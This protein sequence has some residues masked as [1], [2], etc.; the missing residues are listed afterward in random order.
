MP[1]SCRKS[2]WPRKKRAQSL[3]QLHMS[4]AREWNLRQPSAMRIWPW[5]PRL[6]LLHLAMVF[7]ALGAVCPAAVGADYSLLGF[8]TVGYALS[9]MRA[10][11]L[12]Y[13][14]KR[15][16][17]RADSLIGIQGEVQIDPQWGATLQL[18]GGAPRDKDNGFEA[19]IRWAFV[20]YRPSNEWLIRAGRL[21]PPILNHTPNSEVG[22]TY[23]FARLPA[24][25]YSLSPV[26]DLQGVAIARG[27]EHG[28]AESRVETYLGKAEVKFRIPFQRDPSQQV[29]PDK[30][31]P[32]SVDLVGM[33]V[34]RTSSRLSLA[35]GVHHA[36]IRPAQGR[37]FVESLIPL[38]VP[39]PAPLGGPVFVPGRE[40]DEIN[41]LALTVSG[42]YRI[43][44]L[45]ITTEVVRRTISET[46]MGAASNASTV[47]IDYQNDAW[48]PYLRMSRILSPRSTRRVYQ[49]F[50]ST[51]VPILAQF[52]PFSLSPNYHRTLADGVFVYDQKSIALG[53]S[54]RLTP[55]SMLKLEW[56]RSKVGL[57]SV[58]VDGDVHHRSFN[59]LSMSYNFTF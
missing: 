44:R 48:T 4:Q 36:R 41:M 23:D 31:F 59:V 40:I 9:D 51:P 2:V 16:T 11:Y 18:V 3:R 55:N 35:A 30:Y 53:T 1:I 34:T 50:D 54:Y 57:A 8:G 20:S 47:S 56:M 10:P 7:T 5:G 46:R 28:G 17:V 27:W 13:I 19:S 6:G 15:G 33:V 29:F 32:Q 21:R 38:Q 58:F 37:Q 39:A 52:A 42:S 49:D 12:R 24:E 25:V 45:G 22:M 26:Y 14:D 43:G